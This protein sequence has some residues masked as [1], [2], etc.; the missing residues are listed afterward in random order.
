MDNELV[1]RFHALQVIENSN[2]IDEDG[3]CNHDEVRQTNHNLEGAAKI[4]DDE[5][6]EDPYTKGGHEKSA[7]QTGNGAFVY[8]PCVG[9]VKQ[10]TCVAKT[11]DERC[12]YQGE[13]KADGKRNNDI[14]VVYRHLV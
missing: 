8:F 2:D 1:G 5:R 13:H 3:T 7:A 11:H 14:G 4:H 9:L 6:D 12:A 10:S